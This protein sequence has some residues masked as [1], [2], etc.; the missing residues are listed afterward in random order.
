MSS[1]RWHVSKVPK[2]D[3]D[4]ITIR[5]DHRKPYVQNYIREF[6][7]RKCEANALVAAPQAG[8]QLCRNS[9]LQHIPSEAVRT[10]NRKLTS[11][12]TQLQQALRDA[13]SM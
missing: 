5:G 11:A 3:I 9:I 8:R 1:A 2:N 7:V 4:S 10:Y 12:R 13:I 6:G